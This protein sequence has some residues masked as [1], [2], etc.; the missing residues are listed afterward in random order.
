[1][2]NEELRLFVVQQLLNSGNFNLLDYARVIELADKYVDYIQNGK[3]IEKG[4]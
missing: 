3:V 1:M 2:T 4:E